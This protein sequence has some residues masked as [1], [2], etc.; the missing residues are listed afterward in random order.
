MHIGKACS[1]VYSYMCCKSSEHA[2]AND[3][4][5][6][7]KIFM[8]GLYVNE[9]STTAGNIDLFDFRE[10]NMLYSRLH[11]RRCNIALS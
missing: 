11:N 2:H 3:C 7:S 10:Q 6:R 4:K 8:Q 5:V 9:D 1:V